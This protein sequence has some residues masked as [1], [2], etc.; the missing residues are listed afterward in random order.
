MIFTHKRYSFDAFDGKIILF[1]QIDCPCDGFGQRYDY[2][3]RYS[4]LC[5]SFVSGKLWDRVKEIYLSQYND[6]YSFNRYFYELNIRETFDENGISSYLIT[7]FLKCGASIVSHR[8]DS[9]VFYGDLIIPQ[10]MICS[11]CRRK[12]GAVYLDSNGFPSFASI[13]DGRPATEQLIKRKYSFCNN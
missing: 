12:R 8:T 10:K 7:V 9:V 13:A 11:K 3:F 2:L 4:S 1:A 5:Y 6:R